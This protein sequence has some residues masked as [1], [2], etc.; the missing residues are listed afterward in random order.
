MAWFEE[1]EPYSVRA[2]ES[3]MSDYFKQEV[4]FPVPGSLIPRIKEKANPFEK[5]D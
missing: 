2:I 4:M 1:L 3:A 5:K